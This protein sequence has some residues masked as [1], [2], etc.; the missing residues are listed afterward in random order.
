MYQ[1]SQKPEGQL[2]GN[3]DRDDQ[4]EPQYLKQIAKDQEGERNFGRAHGPAIERMRDGSWEDTRTIQ[5]EYKGTRGGAL[6][7]PNYGSTPSATTYGAAHP[8]YMDARGPRHYADAGRSQTLPNTVS[9]KMM[10][11]HLTLGQGPDLAALKSHRHQQED[12][13][14]RRN[15]SYVQESHAVSG[16]TGYNRGRSR[17]SEGH[18]R[19]PQEDHHMQPVV[20][21]I[22]RGQQENYGDLFDSYYDAPQ[23][24]VA[25]DSRH[26]PRTPPEEDMPNFDALPDEQTG[27]GRGMSIDQQ[28]HLAPQQAASHLESIPSE[29]SQGRS[30]RKTT[31]IAGSGNRSRSQPDARGGGVSNI[32]E[33]GFDFG[34]A[35]KVPPLPTPNYLPTAS[36]YDNTY[37]TINYSEPPFRP[38]LPRHPLPLMQKEPDMVSSRFDSEGHVSLPRYG[39]PA[40][41]SI[42]HQDSSINTRLEMNTQQGVHPMVSNVPKS[43]PTGR[44]TNPD[45][46]PQHPTP[47]RPGLL[48]TSPSSASPKPAPVRQYHNT[49]SPVAR[50]SLSQQPQTMVAPSHGNE[51][52]VPV[53]H[54]ELQRLQQ[55]VRANPQDLK[56]QLLLAKKMVEAAS[57]LADEGGRADPKTRTRNRERYVLDAHKIVKKLVNNG[58]PEA[59]FYLADCYGRG[60]L[61]LAPDVKEA[62]ALYQS[63]AKAGHAQSAYR[64]AVCC[65][66]GQEEGGGTRRDP[67]KAMQWYKRAATL[68]DTPAMY[69]M[70]MIQLKGLLGQPRNS[71]EAIVWLKRAAER[72]DEENPHAL[73]ELVSFPDFRTEALWI[74]GWITGSL[75]RKCQWE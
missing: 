41:Q 13:A 44:S 14:A 11:T 50:T 63:A 5:Q 36:A 26:N 49:P 45:T 2:K 67:L 52:P 69:K 72:A 62:F 56:G 60:L 57:V 19:K 48:Q 58:Y 31:N 35:G 22:P 70:G 61:G 29:Y 66:M 71:R 25:P 59:M 42:R 53:T 39:S 8:A 6:P 33:Q 65:E 32:Q 17:S 64:V 12:D 3:Q 38:R 43:P 51:Q 74:N 4:P 27:P 68:G 34:T 73:H 23:V 37:E 9:E 40:N 46:L 18:K 1:A 7:R 55:M 54:Q 10:Q 24:V 20:P 28:L 21:Q 30:D 75:I 16:H 47:V 15:A